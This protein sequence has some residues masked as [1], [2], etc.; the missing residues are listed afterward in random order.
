V[1]AEGEKLSKQTDA[2]AVGPALLP[3]AFE[4][5]GHTLP[6]ELVRAPA[7]DQLAWG[8]AHWEVARLP[9]LRAIALS[10]REG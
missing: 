5:L 10:A 8:I 9:K 1:N 2:H 6:G 7:A 3:A 4:I